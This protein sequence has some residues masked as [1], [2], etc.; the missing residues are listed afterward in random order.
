LSSN[1]DGAK[2]LINRYRENPIPAIGNV[3]PEK[4]QISDTEIP[5][6]EKSREKNDD[7]QSKLDVQLAS[8]H[9]V[10]VVASSWPGDDVAAREHKPPG[11]KN[12]AR[13]P[14]HIENEGPVRTTLRR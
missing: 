6:R 7:D 9:P 10:V 12:I 5:K 2:R 13:F 1:P 14:N 4:S 3:R 11:P 8:K